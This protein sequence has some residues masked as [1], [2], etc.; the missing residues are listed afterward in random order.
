MENVN[1]KRHKLFIKQGRKRPLDTPKRMIKRRGKERYKERYREGGR[2][3]REREGERERDRGERDRGN[4]FPKIMSRARVKK[5]GGR[6][7]S[8]FD[9]EIL[10]KSPEPEYKAL[11]KVKKE[12]PRE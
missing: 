4:V 2:D 7:R 1:I 3:K 12:N 5:G 10:V 9:E 11:R 6:T 8:L